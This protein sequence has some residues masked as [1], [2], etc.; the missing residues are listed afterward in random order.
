M[1]TTKY[2]NI[3]SVFSFCLNSSRIVRCVDINLRPELPNGHKSNFTLKTKI[4][5]KD[6]REKVGDRERDIDKDRKRGIERDTQRD[7]QRDR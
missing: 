4:K 1:L 3:F 6:M 7:T 2:I 5:D